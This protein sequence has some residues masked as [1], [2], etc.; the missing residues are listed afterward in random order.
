MQ[1]ISRL[2]E[3]LLV[4]KEGL[5]SMELLYY[6][7]RWKEGSESDNVKWHPER[8]RQFS[9]P[10][11]SRFIHKFNKRFL[12][13]TW[14]WFI[15]ITQHFCFYITRH[16]FWVWIFIIIFWLE[17]GNNITTQ[18]MRHE[19]EG[20]IVLTATN[21]WK[22]YKTTRRNL[23]FLQTH[24]LRNSFNKHPITAS[25]LSGVW[26]LSAPQLWEKNRTQVP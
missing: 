20:Y 7:G 19:N 3:D 24:V 13:S 4:S 9:G 10:S 14:F 22:G 16:S 23:K 11:P 2:S 8:K 21:F 25:C 15:H 12:P 17:F 26:R 1:G 6:F 5:S 18:T